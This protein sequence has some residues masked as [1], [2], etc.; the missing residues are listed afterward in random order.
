VATPRSARADRVSRSA[1]VQALLAPE[2]VTIVGASPRTSSWGSAIFRNL[3]GHG[4]QGE[5][6]L[7]NPKYATIDGRPCFSDLASVP[8]AP[9]HV[10]IAVPAE[11]VAGVLRQAGKTGA[12]T[13][14]VH[15]GGFGESETAAGR[16]L[17]GELRSAIR[18]SGIA[19]CGPNCLG[20][21]AVPSRA[22]TLSTPVEW[23]PGEGPVAIVGQSGGVV[24]FIHN[25]LRS[26]GV[27]VSFAVS[28]GNETDLT[29]ADYVRCFALN[30]SIK[31]VVCFVEAAVDAGA[32]FAACSL[33][34]ERGTTV[35]AI[36]VGRS[37][38]GRRATLAHTGSLAGTLEA[39][40]AV[41]AQTGLVRC[42]R[43]EDVIEAAEYLSHAPRPK[44]DHIAAVTYSGGLR[45]L[46]LD[47]AERLGT[48][49]PSLDDTTV[50]TLEDVM[51]GQKI[52]NPLDSGFIGLSDQGRYLRAVEAL[53]AD[54]GID[55]VLVQER[56]PREVSNA[57]SHAYLAGLEELARK[58]DKPI[59]V[60][61]ML[62]EGLTEHSLSIRGQFAH[63]PLLHGIDAAIR[64]TVA[65]AGDDRRAR[66]ASSASLPR[67]I[68]RADRGK[69]MDGVMQEA[70][71]KAILCRYGIPV[72]E[73]L[74]VHD[75]AE[76]EAA[77]KRLG[78]PVVV[79]GVARDL[80]HKSEHG[81]VRTGLGTVADAVAA[82]REI[83]ATLSRLSGD[84]SKGMVV[85]Q[86]FGPGVETALGVHWDPEVGPVVMFGWGGSVVE[87]LGDKAFGAPPLTVES[88]Q[89]LMSR[90]RIS[91]ILRG[92]RGGPHYDGEAVVAALV[93]LGELAVRETGALESIDVNPFIVLE[94]GRGAA[95]V[96]VLAS[97]VSDRP[98]L[99]GVGDGK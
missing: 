2:N 30:P 63:L 32:L 87:L 5:I 15:A 55:A 47:A 14:T 34:K 4:F 49:F 82:G 77:A 83:W 20:N 85:A 99:R 19:L 24:L 42:D 89:R 57:H 26:R 18:E 98:E 94:A 31:V 8:E 36:K 9:D 6:Q 72:V 68:A 10:V 58:S 96:D 25:V 13:A 43:L 7:V 44:G 22:I 62:S 23:E 84:D 41:A 81:L 51:G 73:E 95:A 74:V 37:E 16:E 86:H 48:T 3:S 1:D 91:A 93:A 92:Y 71:A 60:F 75:L 21:I 66:Q 65:L 56:L 79:K 80:P 97:R 39:F 64:T 29:T 69:P 33:A 40:D 90:T 53:M 50:R 35:L 11:R 27:G 17:D 46:L 88:A 59:A 38:E 52:S 61:C 12:R 76:V 67:A 70:E 28:S 78:P 54:P 45:E